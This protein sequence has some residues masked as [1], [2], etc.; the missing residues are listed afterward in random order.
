MLGGEIVIDNT[1]DTVQSVDVT[2]SGFLPNVGPFVFVTGVSSLLNFTQ[3]GLADMADDRALLVFSTPTAGSLVGYTGGPLD[4]TFSN[5]RTQA[6]ATNWSLAGSLTEAPPAVPEP[7]SLVLLLSAL[8]GLAG[9][10]FC[11]RR[12]I[13]STIPPAVAGG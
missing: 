10:F 7:P 3:M 11:G 4:P 6:S 1:A 8:A 13:G 5:V 12:R 9:V 2:A